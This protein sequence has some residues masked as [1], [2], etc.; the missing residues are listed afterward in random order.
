[1]L[2]KRVFRQEKGN[3]IFVPCSPTALKHFLYSGKKA[4]KLFS[5]CSETQWRTDLL[6]EP[7]LGLGVQKNTSHCCGS[8]LRGAPLAY[9]IPPVALTALPGRK[10]GEDSRGL[11]TGPHHPDCVWACSWT[12]PRL[13]SVNRGKNIPRMPRTN[14]NDQQCVLMTHS[15]HPIPL[16]LSCLNLYLKSLHKGK[17]GIRWINVATFIIWWSKLAS[18]TSD[19]KITLH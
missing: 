10:W 13:L 8:R 19:M 6:A 18:V 4:I 16:S 5:L 9:E 14:K 1:M 15:P 7:V 3:T 2:W 17:R 12:T 11:L